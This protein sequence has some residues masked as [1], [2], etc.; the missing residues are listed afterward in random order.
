MRQILTTFMSLVFSVSISAG[1]AVEQGVIITANGA[2][3]SIAD[4][5]DSSN[6]LEYIG[7]LVWSDNVGEC[8][9]RDENGEV[10]SCTFNSYSMARFVRELDENSL[11]Q[12]EAN[13]FGT[14]SNLF[15]QKASF[16]RN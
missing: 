12:F 9:A 16:W 7:C 3:G 10:R 15:L 14:C 1:T 2:G 6:D 13:I 5:R 8:Q 4:A 11:F